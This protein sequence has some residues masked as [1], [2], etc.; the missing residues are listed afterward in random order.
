M[1]DASWLRKLKD[2][3]H[4]NLAELEAIIKGLTLAMAWGIQ[5][6]EVVTDSTTVHGWLRSMLC[7]DVP[8]RVKGLGLTLVRRRLTMFED[9]IAECELSV[10][11]S[12]VKSSGNKADVL[13]RVPQEWLKSPSI[14]SVAANETSCYE[15]LKKFHD[16]HHLGVD[17]T[18]YLAKISFPDI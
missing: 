15:K 3:S 10:S 7:G 17:R 5:E 9:I 11:V 18:F 12:W 13:T 1:E 14:C 4:I 8:L 16:V 2:S 6:L